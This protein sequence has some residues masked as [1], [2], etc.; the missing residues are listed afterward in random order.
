MPIGTFGNAGRNSIHGPGIWN[1]NLAILKGIKL[2]ETMSV[3]LRLE[4]FNT[5]NHAQF[6]NPNGN[7]N[8]SLFGRITTAKDPRL[9]QLAA[10]FYF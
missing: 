4:S 5:F 1:T 9:V 3:E 6:N 7:R 10:K 2:N 8:S